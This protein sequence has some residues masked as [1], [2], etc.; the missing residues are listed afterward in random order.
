MTFP[1][2]QLTI[3]S[4]NLSLPALP[5]PL[6]P[7]RLIGNG[8]YRSVWALL[9]SGA[10]RIIFP[11]KEAERIGIADF[12]L[13]VPAVGVGVGR[14]DVFYYNLGLEVLGEGR[15]LPVEV[16][17]AGSLII[18]ILGR[19]FFRHYSEVVFRELQQEVELK[20]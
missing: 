11:A 10:D 13:G 20:P 5:R 8:R 4:T 17:F 1:Y 12:K 15:F 7:V 16:G 19:S 6:L 9:D 3:P 2:R 14:A 18:P